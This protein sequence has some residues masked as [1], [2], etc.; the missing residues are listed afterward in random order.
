MTD[1]WLVLALIAVVG[2]FVSVE[3]CLR[4]IRRK[5]GEIT[6]LRS[7][8]DVQVAANVALTRHCQQ[9]DQLIA[10][11]SEE[12]VNMYLEFAPHLVAEGPVSRRMQ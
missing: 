1:P 7:R 10:A 6:G 3:G 2:A 4:T 11:W 8:L 9:A 12:R 5:D